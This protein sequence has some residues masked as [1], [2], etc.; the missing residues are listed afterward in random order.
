MHIF[1]RVSRWGTDG[2]QIIPLALLV[3]KLFVKTIF[4][5]NVYFDFSWPL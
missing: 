3:E 4:V 5:K 2:I 1:R